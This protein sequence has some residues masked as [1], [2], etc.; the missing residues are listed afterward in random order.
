MTDIAYLIE[1]QQ[2]DPGMR[3][4]EIKATFSEPMKIWIYDCAKTAGTF[5]NL[6]DPIPD[7]IAI[8]AAKDRE[9]FEALKKKFENKEES[10]NV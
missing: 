4:F 7:L 9:Q 2:A 5:I 6:G 8:K 1:W 3:H 10:V